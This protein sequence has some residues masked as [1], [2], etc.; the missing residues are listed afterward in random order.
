MIITDSMLGRVNVK[1]MKRNIDTNEEDVII[2]KFPGGTADE[3]SHYAAKPLQDTKPKRVIL[4]AGTNDIARDVDS[5]R[6]V[7]EYEVV[8]SLMKTARH[9]RSLGAEKVHVSAVIVRHGFQYRNPVTRVNQLLERACAGE[10]FIFMDQS[11]ITPCHICFDGVHLN[12]HGQTLLKMCILSSFHTFNPYFIDFEH[13]YDN[14]L[15]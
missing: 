11:D 13:D 7:N 15:F 6:T 5:G 4:I 2:K 12:F 3:I 8:E 9:A 14:A 10:G 1:Q